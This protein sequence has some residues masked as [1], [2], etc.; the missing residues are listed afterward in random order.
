M[1][2]GN[3]ENSIIITNS[4]WYL[5]NICAR[6]MIRDKTKFNKFK[7]KENGFVTHIVTITKEKFLL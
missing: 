7:E 2:K 3:L 1:M 5:D 4:Q 6:H